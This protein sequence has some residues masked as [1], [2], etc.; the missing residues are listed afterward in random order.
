MSYQSE[1]NEIIQEIKDVCKKILDT[2]IESLTQEKIYGTLGLIE[3]KPVIKNIKSRAKLVIEMDL[4]PF[5]IQKLERILTKSKEVADHFEKIKTSTPEEED[6]SIQKTKLIKGLLDYDAQ[7]Y[8]N[9]S[10]LLPL[11]NIN[12]NRLS[13]LEQRLRNAD[14]GFKDLIKK[15]TEAKK[16]ITDLKE[17]AGE[18]GVSEHNV[19]FENAM[20]EHERKSRIWLWVT[21]ILT[22]L[23]V[24]LAFSSYFMWENIMEEMNTTKAIHFGI[25]KLIVFS[26]LYFGI[27]W[28]SKIYKSQQHNYIINC[29]RRNALN[30]FKT[31]VDATTDPN[32][33]DAV[34]L[35]ATKSIFSPLNSGFASQDSDREST[36]FIEI[37]RNLIAHK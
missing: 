18:A 17:M 27:I 21:G 24:I 16:I 35:E 33:K 30:T 2:H 5:P 25:T 20:R 36:T 37:V 26:I 19:H 12:E 14:S 11:S 31:F 4:E 8:N 34:L 22:F 29:H 9:V 13:A 3:I 1:L 23:T 6:Y 15:N 10:T 28:S 7:F 32:I